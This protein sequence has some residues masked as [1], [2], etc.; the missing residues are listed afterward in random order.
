MDAS[1]KGRFLDLLKRFSKDIANAYGNS[2]NDL[3]TMHSSL[4][5]VINTFPDMACQVFHQHVAQPYGEKIKVRDEAFFMSPQLDSEV[6]T[7]DCPVDPLPFIK[8]LRTV[9]ADLNEQDK[10]NVWTYMQALVALSN[11]M[12]V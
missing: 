1:I 12:F 5:I 10:G 3:H 11:R 9:W 4:L 6:A 8:H 2:G 7:R